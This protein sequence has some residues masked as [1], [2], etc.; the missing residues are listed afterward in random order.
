MLV[1]TLENRQYLSFEIRTDRLLLAAVI[2]CAAAVATA[3]VA[4]NDYLSIS[5]SVDYMFW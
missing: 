2:V 1:R 3:V 4:L 5:G